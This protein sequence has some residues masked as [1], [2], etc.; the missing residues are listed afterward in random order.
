MNKQGLGG[1]EMKRNKWIHDHINNTGT[2]QIKPK[3][4]VLILLAGMLLSL[5]FM[6]CGTFLMRESAYKVP[7]LPK[8]ELATIQ[9]DTERQWIQRPNLI[10]QVAT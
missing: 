9:I 10:T 7:D 5:P 4:S 8:S 3:L 6:G 2:Q 1:K